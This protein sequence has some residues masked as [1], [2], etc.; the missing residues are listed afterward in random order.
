[1]LIAGCLLILVVLSVFSVILGSSFMGIIVEQTISNTVV[2]NG[3]ATTFVVESM[4]FVFNID[5]IAGMVGSL[6]LWVGIALVFGIQ[7]FG[8]GLSDD[9]SRIATMITIYTA[10][11]TILSTLVIPLIFAIEVFG[12]I[13]YVVLT[14]AY[15][16]GV[17]QKI[18]GAD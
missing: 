6:A 3:S 5:P 7:I 4:E 11:W 9:A 14:I 1:M 10:I 12:A 18:G 15:A 16:V 13:I 17:I 8:T 2:V